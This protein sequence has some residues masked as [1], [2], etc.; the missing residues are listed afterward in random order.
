MFMGALVP[1]GFLLGPQDPKPYRT[2]V[3]GRSVAEVAVR[4]SAQQGG[5]HLV[6]GRWLE[7]SANKEKE[8][9][10]GLALCTVI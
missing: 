10:E 8:G 4:G 2:P 5:G 9:S 3:R 1:T 6:Q 7:P